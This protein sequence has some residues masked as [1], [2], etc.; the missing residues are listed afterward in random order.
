MQTLSRLNRTRADKDGTFVLD[1]V[2][3]AGQIAAAFEP[4]YGGGAS[5]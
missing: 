1:F 5:S 3:E 4:Y 2:N